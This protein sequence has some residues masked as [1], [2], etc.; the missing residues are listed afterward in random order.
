MPITDL[1]VQKATGISVEDFY[2]AQDA[3]MQ[4]P[5]VGKRTNLL[6]YSCVILARVEPLPTFDGFRAMLDDDIDALVKECKLKNPRHF[7]AEEQADP[8]GEKKS[9][10]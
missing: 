3:A 1:K 2:A 9:A 8:D 7:P 10:S 5:A 6:R 4:E